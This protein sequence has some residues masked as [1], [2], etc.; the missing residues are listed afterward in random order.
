VGRVGNCDDAL[1][2]ASE[3][4]GQRWISL[5]REQNGEITRAFLSG[6]STDGPRTM[7]RTFVD[8]QGESTDI[9]VPQMYLREAGL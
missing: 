6:W 8:Y 1:T 4:L 9:N 3:W 5:E 2:I 7:N